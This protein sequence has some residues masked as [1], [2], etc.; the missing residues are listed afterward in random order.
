MSTT[1]QTNDVKANQEV[2]AKQ[3][4]ANAKKKR[5]TPLKPVHHHH[6]H[7][8]TVTT[9]EDHEQLENGNVTVTFDGP[10]DPALIASHPVVLDT[11]DFK[12]VG[13]T[14]LANGGVQIEFERLNSGLPHPPDGRFHLVARKPVTK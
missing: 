11:K 3:A 12:E 2:D 4:K 7:G 6:T 14:D 8:A 9:F 1:A 10:T 13:R 5:D